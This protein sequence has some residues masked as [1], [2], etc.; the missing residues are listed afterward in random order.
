MAGDPKATGG[1]Q[2]NSGLPATDWETIY[3]I[4]VE[5]NAE[6]PGIALGDIRRFFSI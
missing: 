6:F 4:N 1:A 3:P 2:P 5:K